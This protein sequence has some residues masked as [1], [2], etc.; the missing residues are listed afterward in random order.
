MPGPVTR[1][2][3]GPLLTPELRRI[4]MQAGLERPMEHPMW[5]NTEPME[6]NP[7][8]DRE[9]SELGLMPE[10]DEGGRF[11]LDAPIKGNTVTYTA[12]I[13]GLGFEITR[14]MIEDDMYG[15]MRGMPAGL[16]KSSRNRMEID[17]H[18]PLNRAFN[19]SYTGF[20]G[21][22]LCST[23]HTRLDGGATQSNRSATD[24]SFSVAGL[25]QMRLA[26]NTRN[27]ARGFPALM[28]AREI[29]ITEQNVDAAREILGSSS[30]PYTANNE[31]NSLVQDELTYLVS[32]W[33]TTLSNWFAHAAKGTHDVTFLTRTAP[34]F[35]TYTDP[36][37]G[38][39]ISTVWQ[40]H[41]NGFGDWAGWWGSRG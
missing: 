16:A 1:G 26:F 27:N 4:Y 6:G 12:K 25:Q 30:R 11:P 38:N 14:P 19:S 33:I 39:V 9:Y 15:V 23:A 36:A 2:A 41:T 5:T 13:Y 24:I 35:D 18:A 40:R 29:I 17:A 3:H 32:H 20:D 31:I 22:P 10:M 7:V 8:T 37:T 21:Q 34:S 28:S